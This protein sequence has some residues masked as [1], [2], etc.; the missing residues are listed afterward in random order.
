[1]DGF[2]NIV[3]F[4][5][6]GSVTNKLPRLVLLAAWHSRDS[7]TNNFSHF[8]EYVT[9]LSWFTLIV[10]LFLEIISFFSHGGGSCKYIFLPQI[11]SIDLTKT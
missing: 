3:K 1:M 11:P 8:S 9:G 10:P 6:G 7:P 2:C 5:Q 4:A